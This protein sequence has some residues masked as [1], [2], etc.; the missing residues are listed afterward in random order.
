MKSGL[1]QQE[2]TR[3]SQYLRESASL[4]LFSR[5]LHSGFSTVTLREIN[6]KRHRNSVP[7][8]LLHTFRVT[9]SQSLS[10]TSIFNLEFSPNGRTL[11]VVGASG[12]VTLCDT[13]NHK[14][15][16]TISNAHDNCANVAKFIND[17]HFL[18]GSDDRTVRLWDMRKVTSP[19]RIF[20]GHQGW[21]KNIEQYDNN[22]ILT[23]AFD[24]TVRVWSLNSSESHIQ[25][26]ESN[27]V[28]YDPFTT[29]MKLA[30]CEDTNTFKMI[31]SLNGFVLVIHNL[32]LE[33]ASSDLSLN[34]QE[35]GAM[36]LYGNF[37]QSES[38]LRI[39]KVFV[40]SYNRLEILQEPDFEGFTTSLQLSEDHRYL[41]TRQTMES[42]EEFLSVF[43]LTDR[44]KTLQRLK[45]LAL[46]EE[47]D[48]T[49]ATASHNLLN[50]SLAPSQSETLLKGSNSSDPLSKL[51]TTHPWFPNRL[52]FRMPDSHAA[53]GYIKELCFSSCNNLICSPYYRG[54][55][56]FDFTRGL[57]KLK[58]DGSVSDLPLCQPLVNTHD[59]CV[60]TT[61][62]HPQLPMFASGG[63]DG[64]VNFYCP[65]C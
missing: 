5:R 63:M 38:K 59:D 18:T 22:T 49:T 61:R 57:Q 17:C 55:R 33:S 45:E 7:R 21:V 50:N 15:I 46:D 23:A 10:N 32:R 40:R 35:L 11:V 56:V 30:R 20:L 60:L 25:T 36:Y 44:K 19:L 39:P 53:R 54:V 4:P 34:Y 51:N 41:L 1:A 42:D 52:L 3:T 28:F 26:V 65:H 47:A 16:H 58:S 13:Y 27:I 2:M 48:G 29:R 43:D 31:V 24:G 9:F 62:Y 8:S 37:D 64:K 12:D 6:A 14:V